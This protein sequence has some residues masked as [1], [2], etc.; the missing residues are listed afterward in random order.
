MKSSV[1]SYWL[2]F[3]SM[4]VVSGCTS[5]P[6][7]NPLP[8]EFIDQA[9]IPGI[10]DARHWAD[11]TYGNIGEWLNQPREILKANMPDSFGKPHNYLAISGGG[12]KGA[13]TAGLL[14]GWTEAGTR[15]EFTIVTGV[16]TGA[17]IAPFAF[18]GS[19]YDHVIKAVYTQLSTDDVMNKP[20]GLRAL[21]GES[22]ASTEPLQK[23]I[24]KYIDAD[25][26]EKIAAE[27]KKGRV[28][29]IGTTNLDTGRPV[30]WNIT[31]I[32]S[33]GA[34]NAVQLIQD[35]VLASAA[36]PIAFPPVMFDVEAAGQPY[37]E[38]H[39]DGGVASIVYLYP[40][41]VDWAHV[42]ELLEV[43]GT[44]N[45]YVIRNSQ[46]NDKYAP[47][48]RT[49]LSIVSRTLSTLMQ[50]VA[51]GDMQRIYLAAER[52]G[53]KYQLAYIPEYF[54]TPLTEPFDSTYMTQL[55]ILG[56]DLAAD[57]YRWENAPPGYNTEQ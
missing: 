25:L 10:P 22:A 43:E 16:S 34:P 24:A 6:E 5:T 21:F 40:L 50:K 31:R 7:R 30:S 2:I 4:T 27:D 12:A 19:E 3:I 11:S 42:L 20:S 18:L 49:T 48:Q 26:I 8:E 13:F 9:E 52:D 53:L 39:V 55:Y 57:G 1:L 41:G 15:P 14:N 46:L 51:D 45:I 32:A 56:Y 54:N 35:I 17:I 47:A 23:K 33:S 36:V 37:D 38:L 44:P 28:L 29:M